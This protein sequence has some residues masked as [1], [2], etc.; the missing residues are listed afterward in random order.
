VG[1]AGPLAFPRAARSASSFPTVPACEK[2]NASTTS[3]EVAMRSKAA[4]T[5]APRA[6]RPWREAHHLPARGARGG[7]QQVNGP[8]CTQPRVQHVRQLGAHKSCV[9]RREDPRGQHS[10]VLGRC[11][12]T[13]SRT[14]IL[15]DT[16]RFTIDGVMLSWLTRTRA[17][18]IASAVMAISQR[19][20]CGLRMTGPTFFLPIGIITMEKL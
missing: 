18:R 3:Y 11:T 8:R 13:D 14:A 19:S 17:Q 10:G 5:S 7:S 12:H 1:E 2:I 6:A 15:V 16:V 9:H 4:H 20:C